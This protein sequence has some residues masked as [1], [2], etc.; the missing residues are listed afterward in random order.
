MTSR[1]RPRARI[2]LDLEN[3][4]A[5]LGVSP[6][7]SVDEIKQVAANRRGELIKRR[8]SQGQ[9]GAGDLE[10]QIIEIQDIEKQIAAPAARAAYDR[11]H[12][13]SVLLTVQAGPRDRGLGPVGAIGLV[14]AWLA[15][16]LGADARLI[17]PD[18]LWLWLPSGLDPVLAEAL[19]RFGHDDQA[20][21]AIEGCESNGELERRSHG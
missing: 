13:Q 3:P 16:E 15:E 9:D 20:A 5:R 7:A 8:R 6:L 12:P 18:A 1:P 17:H 2:Q 14:T 4:Y 21:P 19:T 10:Q 11:E